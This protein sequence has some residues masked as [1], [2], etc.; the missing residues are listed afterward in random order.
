MCGVVAIAAQDGNGSCASVLLTPRETYIYG[1]VFVDRLVEAKRIT[2]FVVTS[3]QNNSTEKYEKH[4][5]L[6]LNSS[7][8]FFCI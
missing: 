1:V 3:C 2:L 6:F 7:H 8:S 5:E 4:S